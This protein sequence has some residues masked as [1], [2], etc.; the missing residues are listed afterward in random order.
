MVG[1]AYLCYEGTEKAFETFF[2]YEPHVHNAELKSVAPNPLT[3]EDK[4]VASAIKT[5][6][7]LSAEI[8]AI[9]LA[10]VSSA[11]LVSQAITLGLVGIGITAVVY[12]AVAMVVKVDDIGVALARQDG[13]SAGTRMMRTLGRGLVGGMPVFLTLLAVVGTAAMIWVGGAILVHGLK[14]YGFGGLENAIHHAAELAAHAVPA[15]ETATEWLITAAGSGLVGVVVGTALIPTTEYVLTPIWRRLT[16]A[17]RD[18]WKRVGS[19]A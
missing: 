8:M 12:G 9:T 10:D 15:L 18:M 5:D 4:K 7:I 13:T 17:R 14:D 19:G 11:S 1:G 3:L 6:L 2:A 16:S